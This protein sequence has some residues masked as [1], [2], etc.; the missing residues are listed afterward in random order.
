[1]PRRGQ[2][3]PVQ[4]WLAKYGLRPGLV[5][6]GALVAV[7]IGV[8]AGWLW[9]MLTPGGEPTRPP[10]E[11]ATAVDRRA[12]RPAAAPTPPSAPQSTLPPYEEP[13]AHLPPGHVL[14]AMD[15]AIFSALAAGGVTPRNITVHMVNGPE[16]ELT[17][18]HARLRPGQDASALADAVQ[19]E[20]GDMA[21]AKRG[22]IKSGVRLAVF[23]AGIPTHHLD[24]LPPPAEQRPP[25]PAWPAKPQIALIMDDVGYV[26]GPVK[27]LL[28]LGLPVTL[29]IL[30]HSPLAAKIQRMAKKQGVEVLV[31]LPMEPKTYP[32]LKPGPGALLSGQSPEDMQRI[33]QEDL[34]SVA[35]A[36]GANNH[37]GSRLTEDQA[38]M[39]QV[40][41]ALKKRGMFFVDSVTS[42]R[43][44][45]MR[46][47]RKAGV[48]TGR[49]HVFLDHDQSPEAIEAQIQRMFKLARRKGKII[50]IAHP[51]PATIKA[52]KAHARR[53]KSE[54]EMVPVSRLILPQPA[55]AKGAL[56]GAPAQSRDQAAPPKA[57]P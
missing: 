17:V 30:P 42:P 28:A 37:M 44:L 19:R 6:S 20:L 1:M 46:T 51:H 2:P 12:D 56:A 35:S 13:P 24:L 32:R 40:M 31:H 26:M 15:E 29:S 52:L 33:I 9:G 50:V 36:Q 49:R 22:P 16:G 18:I 23:H 39:S 8:V 4:S 3:N 47:A 11:R 53:L 55:T 25:G 10:T 54:V 7:L 14:H 5:I 21:Q 27:D 38:A 57:R 45:A 41:G 34:A 43:S 48:P